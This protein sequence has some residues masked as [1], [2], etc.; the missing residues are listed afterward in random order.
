[1]T[2]RLTFA[3]NNSIIDDSK[4]G[5]EKMSAIDLVILGIVLESP[6]AHMTF[7]RMLNTTIFQGG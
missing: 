2:I 6:K 7:K 4:T 5:G 1:M 3:I